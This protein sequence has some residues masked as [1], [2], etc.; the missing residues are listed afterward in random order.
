M[1][2]SMETIK[3][4]ERNAILSFKKYLLKTGIVSQ[5]CSA[6]V[7]CMMSWFNLQ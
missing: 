2:C 6:C 7:A 3:E 1:N 5:F 4:Q